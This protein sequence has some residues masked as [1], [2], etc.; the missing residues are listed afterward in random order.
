MSLKTKH[1]HTLIKTKTKKQEEKKWISS[2]HIAHRQSNPSLTGRSSLF[3]VYNYACRKNK[4]NQNLFNN[5]FFPSVDCNVCTL[6]NKNL[7]KKNGAKKLFHVRNKKRE[8][9][10][11]IINCHRII[12]AFP[13]QWPCTLQ[14]VK[15]LCAPVIG[16]PP[17]V[18]CVFID[19]IH[20]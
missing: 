4:E 7:P 19:H 9:S 6:S 1:T 5:V 20:G 18:R 16:E 14:K 13:D 8:K 17:A 2:P 10:M 3:T 11:I 12:A 15:W